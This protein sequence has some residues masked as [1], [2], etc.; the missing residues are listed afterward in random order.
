MKAG[1]FETDITSPIGTELAASYVKNYITG[2]ATPIKVRAV[3]IS[4]G[5]TTVAIAAVDCGLLGTREAERIKAETVKLCGHDFDAVLLSATHT[6]SAAMLSPMY[7][8]RIVEGK[9]P[10]DVLEACKGASEP[11]KAFVDFAIRQAATAIKMADICQQEVLTACDKGQDAR[12]VFNRRMKMRDGRACTHPGKMHVDIL[13]PAGPVDPE[14]G[15]IGFWKTDGTPL[16]CLVNYACHGTCYSRHE[17]HGDWLYHVDETL[18]RLFGPDFGVVTING[19]CGDITQVDNRSFTMDYGP[20]VALELGG[21]VGAEAYKAMLSMR[22]EAY[23]VL[24]AKTKV[25]GVP[26][27]VQDP[28]KVAKAHGILAEGQEK[29]FNA[30]MFARERLVAFAL[31]QE[32]PIAPVELNAVQIGSAIIL[33]NPAELFCKYGMEIKDKTAFPVTFVSDLTNGCLGYCGGLEAFD[34]NTGGGYETLIT[35]ATN[36]A[37]DAA[38]RIT[39]AMIDLGKEFTPEAE[40]T[41]L[42]GTPSTSKWGF[43]ALGPERD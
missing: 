10:E 8:T 5:N 19:A 32:E 3:V 4:S 33:S 20:K 14:V 28:A 2:I 17:T 27:R 21:R 1:F 11:D 30:Y 41:P 36:L 34:P 9:L 38:E 24:K 35:S 37:I 16:G 23:R 18:K 43:G 15:I 12:R 22:P 39:T 42:T 25:V 26:R 29:D 6:H 13:E 40:P 31:Q 7:D